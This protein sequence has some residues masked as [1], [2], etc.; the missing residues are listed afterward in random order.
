MPTGPGRPGG[1]PVP[2][3]PG[4]PNGQGFPPQPAPGRPPIPPAERKVSFFGAR[5]Q[6]ASL[7]EDNEALAAQNADLQ[8]LVAEVGAMGIAERER[9]KADLDAEIARKTAELDAEIARRTAELEAQVSRLT[10]ELHAADVELQRVQ[11]EILQ[12]RTTA[13]MQDVGLYEYHHPAES[14]VDLKV[15]LDET[16]ARIKQMV[17]TKTAATMTETLTYE[18]SAAKGKKFA[19]DMRDMML[20][21]YN[22]EAENCVKS[23]K[24]GNLSAAVARLERSRDRIARRGDM[25]DV[26]ITWDFHRLRVKELELAADYWQMKEEEKEAERAR[27]E[28][29]REQRKAEQELAREQ[30]EAGE[31]AP[32]LPVHPRRAGGQR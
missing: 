30:G 21:A 24:A 1:G 32:A 18:G 13:D 8:R 7:M 12:V 3:V 11:G 22:A 16:R 5:K 26:A 29:L 10:G 14:S 9:R 20:A 19:K 27:R 25:V 23:V 28:E 6:A 31:G 4:G 15:A 17:Q 2:S